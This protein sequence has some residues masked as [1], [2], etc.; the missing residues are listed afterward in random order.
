MS[1]STRILRHIEEFLHNVNELR[2]DPKTV[3]KLKWLQFHFAHEENVSLTCRHFCIAR[4]TL[5]RWLGRFDHND[6]RSLEEH[7]KKPH[8]LREP[9]IDG[10]VIALIEMYRRRTPLLG[11]E[12]LA[13]VLATEH[14]EKISASSVGRVIER[15]RFYFAD[16]PLHRRKRGEPEESRKSHESSSGS[17]P[18]QSRFLFS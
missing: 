16:T 18:I 4:S 15:H 8:K 10:T 3:M 9:E 14:G 17:F 6:I 5:L 13:H 12:E 7:S 2:L 11:K 1:K